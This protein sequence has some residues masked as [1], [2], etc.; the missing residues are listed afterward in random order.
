MIWLIVIDIVTR[1]SGYRQVQKLHQVLRGPTQTFTVKGAGT[2]FWMS[3]TNINTVIMDSS[4]FVGVR[5]FNPGGTLNI[6][7]PPRIKTGH[8]LRNLFLRHKKV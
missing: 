2:W 6:N 3:I 7:A 4:E 8:D 5:E 1:H